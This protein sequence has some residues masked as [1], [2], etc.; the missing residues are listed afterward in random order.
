MEALA[1][2]LTAA[3]V[4]SN[5]LWLFFRDRESQRAYDERSELLTRLQHPTLVTPRAATRFDPGEPPG[6]ERDERDL[7]GTVQW[8]GVARNGDE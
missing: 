7:A 1:G 8:G 3:L 6:P 5:G 4:V 2:V